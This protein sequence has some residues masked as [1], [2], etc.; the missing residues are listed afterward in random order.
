M[1]IIRKRDLREAL[2]NEVE[3]RKEEISKEENY[4]L[5]REW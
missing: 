5:N 1:R 2:M 3:P 4:K